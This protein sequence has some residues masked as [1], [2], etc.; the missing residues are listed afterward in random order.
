MGVSSS[1]TFLEITTMRK[2]VLATALAAAAALP[3]LASAQA[4]SP[5]TI[6]GNMGIFSDYRFRGFSQTF[7]QPAI[8]GG[9]DYSHSSGFYLG[10]WNSNVNSLLY[11]DGSIEMDFYGGYKFN[12]GPVGMDVGLLQYYY[13]GAKAG[14][15]KYDTVEAYVA[16]SWK[17]FTLKYSVT[18]G[19][20]FGVA[21]SD[22][23]GYLDLSASYEVAPKLTLS[24]HYGKQ[25]VKNSSASDYADYKVGLSYDLGG[26]GLG[27][28]YIDTD[29]TFNVTNVDGKTKDVAKG[30]V[31]LSIGKSF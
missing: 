29:T 17:W 11:T 16:G 6:S 1:V 15:V 14:G 9:I 24:A 3:G 5:H 12:A 20:W 7:E 10:N 28:A 22:G 27:L 31:V 13:P 8:Q 18:T 2:T 21:N 23:S 25:T 19:D 26:W 4:T 30:T